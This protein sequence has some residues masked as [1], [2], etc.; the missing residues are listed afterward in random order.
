VTSVSWTCDGVRVVTAGADG[1]VRSWLTNLDAVIDLA[2]RDARPFT[3]Q[4]R[5][6]YAPLLEEPSR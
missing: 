6:T 2:D 3:K 5:E 4:E 1:T